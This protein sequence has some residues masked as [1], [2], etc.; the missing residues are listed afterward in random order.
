VGIVVHE[1]AFPEEVLGSEE[2]EAGLLALRRGLEQLHLPILNDKEVLPGAVLGEK[3][4][5]RLR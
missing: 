2:G 4:T 3:Q 1:G 5:A